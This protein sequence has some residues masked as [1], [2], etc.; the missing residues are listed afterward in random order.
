MRASGI[1]SDK[2]L[3]EGSGLKTERTPGFFRK[4]RMPLFLA[5]L[6]LC[7]YASSILYILLVR[8]QVA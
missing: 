1:M 4:Y 6:A 3:P 8:G 7:L 5:L 2:Q